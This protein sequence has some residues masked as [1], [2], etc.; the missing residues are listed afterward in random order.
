M[1]VILARSRTSRASWRG[2]GG[3]RSGERECL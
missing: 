3:G 2:A 1:P